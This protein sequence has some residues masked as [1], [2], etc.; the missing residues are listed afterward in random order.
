MDENI[1]T[2]VWALLI[3]GV[4]RIFLFEAFAIEGPSMEPTLYNEDRV[5]VAK[6][7]YGIRFPFTLDA[8][9][10]WGEPEPGEIII[11]TSPAD[12]VDIVKRVIGVPGDTIQV[13]DNV[14]LR[15][16]KPIATGQS[17]SCGTDESRMHMDDDCQWQEEQVG[18]HTYRVSHGEYWEGP[19]YG[20][21]TIPP[22]HVFVMGDH[23]DRSNDSRF[24]G[25]VPVSR[26]KGKALAVYWSG[27]LPWNDVRWSRLGS[28]LH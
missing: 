12:D 16:G 3:A 26:I 4:I 28:V 7:P 21:E 19:D 1:L 6:Y 27:G 2:V 20:P 14:V 10:N 17:G 24:F 8:V 15:N 18:E 9:V 25:V 13:R 5:V 23:R 11:V 22:N